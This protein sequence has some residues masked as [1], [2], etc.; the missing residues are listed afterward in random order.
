MSA[1]EIAQSFDRDIDTDL[2]AVLETVG[3][4]LGRRVDGDRYPSMR[5]ISIPSVRADP[6]KRTTLSLG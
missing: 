2:V 3:D 5:W 4:R 6:E 1:A